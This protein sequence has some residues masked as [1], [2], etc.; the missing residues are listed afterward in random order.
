MLA[1]LAQMGQLPVEDE[2]IANGLYTSA[3]YASADMHQNTVEDAQGEIDAHVQRI[4]ASQAEKMFEAKLAI[5]S[6]HRCKYDE[7]FASWK[8]Q[9]WLDELQRVHAAVSAQLPPIPPAQPN[10]WKD[11][12][13]RPTSKRYLSRLLEVFANADE[14]PTPT[15]QSACQRIAGVLC[16]EDDS[17]AIWS[18]GTLKKHGRIFEKLLSYDGHFDEIRVRFLFFRQ[19]L[20]PEDSIGSHAC[21][22]EEFACLEPMAFL[23]DVHSLTS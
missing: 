7:L 9:P 2:D 3:A 10:P 14:G 20:T 23:S 6:R 11:L 19:K 13:I 15:M 12:G 16:N 8:G 1:E 18:F 22:L 5:M 4:G 17:I 21:S